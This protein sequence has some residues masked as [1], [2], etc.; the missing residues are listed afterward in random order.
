MTSSLNLSSEGKFMFKQMIVCLVMSVI[1]FDSLAFNWDKC[2][3]MINKDKSLTGGGFFMSTTS[4]VSSVGE[5]AMIGQADHDKK[6]FIVFN[7]DMILNDLAKGNGEYLATFIKLNGCS[8]S[9]VVMYSQIQRSKILEL[10][11]SYTRN[12]YEEASNMLEEPFTSKTYLR[13]CNT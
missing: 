8:K 12:D 1:S 13:Y 5:C 9:S 11:K 4:F 10:S 3:S 7:L 2:R 6:V